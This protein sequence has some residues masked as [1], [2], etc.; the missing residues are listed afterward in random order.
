[1][2]TYDSA[3]KAKRHQMSAWYDRE[4]ER[5]GEATSGNCLRRETLAKRNECTKT[6]RE[7]GRIGSVLEA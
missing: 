2:E 5:G 6:G 7:G 4:R 1:M 3:T